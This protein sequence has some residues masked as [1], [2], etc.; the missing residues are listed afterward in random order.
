MDTALAG[1]TRV[2][3]ANA[4]LRDTY[5]GQHNARFA[6]AAEEEGVAFVGA[7]GV[8]LREVLCH[9]EERQVGH[10]NTVV[11]HK[12]RLQIP[13]SPLRAHYVKAVVRVRRCGDGSHGVFHR[14]RCIGR[15]DAL[16]LALAAQILAIVLDGQ[17]AWTCS[18]RCSDPGH[19]PDQ[20]R[21]R[22]DNLSA[23]CTGQLGSIPTCPDS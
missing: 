22:A 16:G 12:V 17:D 4:Y 15:Y 21:N 13:P 2:A 11:L 3:A 8:D 1:I 14:P 9:E 20:S 10:D 7:P 6:V 23:P 5:I 18:T 19:G